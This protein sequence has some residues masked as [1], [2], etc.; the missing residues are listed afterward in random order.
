MNAQISDNITNAITSLGGVLG[1]REDAKV[2]KMYS[3]VQKLELAA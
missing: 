2:V 1:T 3:N